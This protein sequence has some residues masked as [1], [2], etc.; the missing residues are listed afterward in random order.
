MTDTN[1]HSKEL[2]ERAA[3][4]CGEEFVSLRDEQLAAAPADT[5]QAAQLLR[6]CDDSR[7]PVA[8]EGLGS[9][10]R[11]LD[12]GPTALR[13]STR[14]TNAVLEH[15]WQDMTCTVQ[16]GCIWKDMQDALAQHGQFVALD[17]LWPEHSTVGG[18]VGANDSGALRLRYG[19]LRDLLIGMTVALADG[20][21][22][23]SGGKVVKNVAGYDLPKL[24]CGSFGTLALIT[25]VTF[26]LHSLA[27][28][29]VSL[30]ATSPDASLLGKLLLRLLDSHFSTQSL[31]MR[32]DGAGYSLD[33]R[34]AALPDVLQVQAD[35][36][37]EVAGSMGI[38]AQINAAEVWS[39]RE[40]LFQEAESALV[41]K[42]TML[43]A[44]IGGAMQTIMAMNGSA[45]AQG[46]GILFG[47]VHSGE[48]DALAN[49]RA[50]LEAAG[51]SL[52]LLQRPPDV[53]FDRWGRTPSA[54]PLMRAVKKQFDPNG[55]L[56]SGR[57][58]GGL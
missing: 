4:I 39:A 34:L 10:S 22:A 41:F 28:H 20:T 2:Y 17:P 43:P 51:G 11:W 26:R 13:L 32:T 42:A 18:V 49:F 35:G 55:I 58:F 37:I 27:P 48:R 1:T 53:V 6:L 5:S 25:E 45:V 24:L 38:S 33:V 3:A 16:A 56:H 40:T 8:I 9:K 19:G 15:T 29:T 36:L 12:D 47:R 46:N 14:R 52:V 7:V 44:E 31:Q 54:L 21:V 23:R 50:T 57:F 30:T